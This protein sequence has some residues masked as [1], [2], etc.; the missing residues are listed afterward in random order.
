MIENEKDKARR[1]LFGVALIVGALLFWA[2]NAIVG[3]LAPDA[4]VPPVGLNFWRWTLAFLILLPIALP[5]LRAQRE[6]FL[7]YWWL[8]SVFGIVTVAGFNTVFYIGL[9]YTTAVQGLLIVSIL[10]ILVVIASRV[11]FGEPI[12]ARQIIG[13]AISIAGVGL[14][15]MRGDPAVIRSLAL[16][17]GDAWILLALLFWVAQIL[18]IRFLPKGMDLIA[19]QVLAFVVGLAVVAPF[20][21]GETILGRPMPIS[22]PALLYVG[23]TAVFAS[24]LGFTFWN[25][26]VVRLGPKNAG[27]LANLYP[28]FGAA[29]GIVLLGEALEWYHAAGAAV[30]L[31]G[32]YLATMSGPRNEPARPSGAAPVRRNAP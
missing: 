29:F 31:G 21:I 32:I 18:L 27:Y 14:I 12:T 5:K 2:G 28:V 17:V 24:V 30:I 1:S 11:F 22:V 6:L 25:M 7:A 23:Y 19:F 16:N 26:G 13:A 10:P 4:D 3:R 15:V 20:Y 9:Q 8:W